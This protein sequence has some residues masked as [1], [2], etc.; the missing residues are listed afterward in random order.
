MPAQRSDSSVM[1]EVH[2]TNSPGEPDASEAEKLQPLESISELKEGDGNVVKLTTKDLENLEKIQAEL[3]N[4]TSYFPH[5]EQS[6]DSNLK[7]DEQTNKQ[8]I[9]SNVKNVK[10]VVK[11]QNTEQCKIMNMVSDNASVNNVISSTGVSSGIT[12][13][14]DCTVTTG[15]SASSEIKQSL[16]FVPKHVS[17]T[18]PIVLQTQNSSVKSTATISSL[19]SVPCVSKPK[20]MI[21]TETVLNSGIQSSQISNPVGSHLTTIKGTEVKVIVSQAI[22]PTQTALVS[23]P[24]I[25]TSNALTAATLKRTPSSTIG[26]QMITKVIIK[27]NPTTHQPAVTPIAGSLTAT[28]TGTLIAS[29]NLGQQSTI[30]LASPTKTYTMSKS[31]GT[32]G[33]PRIIRS[34]PSTPP[35]QNVVMFSRVKGKVTSPISFA[36]SPQRI[37]PAPSTGCLIPGS[38]VTIVTAAAAAVSSSA[39]ATTIA[40]PVTT[41]SS[42]TKVILKPVVPTTMKPGTN[43]STNQT[44]TVLSNVDNPTT[45]KQVVPVTGNTVQQIQVP[46]SKFH[47]VR[48]VTPPSQNISGTGNKQAT[49]IP[50]TTRPIVTAATTT[51]NNSSQQQSS[52]ISSVVNVSSGAPVKLTL[53]IS[54]VIAGQTQVTSKS[55]SVPQ[56]MLIPASSVTSTSRTNTSMPTMAL[57]QLPAG[58][59]IPAAGGSILM[60]PAQYNIAQLQQ[61]NQ[62]QSNTLAGTQML[63]QSVQ[64]HNILPSPT[65]GN[66][67]NSNV[68]Q[69]NYVPVAAATTNQIFDHNSSQSLSS[70]SRNH[71]NGSTE[72]GDS[73]PRKPCNCTKSQCLKLY[74]DCFANGEFCNNC[75][76]NNCSNNLEHEEERQKAIKACLDRNPLAFHPKIGKGKDGDHERRHTKGCN[77]KRSGCLKNYCEC[78]EAKILCTNLCKCVG[79]KNFEDS[80]ERKT[81]M[82][83]ADAAEVRVQQQAAA[84]TKI[85]SQIQDLPTRPPIISTTGERLPF[86]FITQEV[87][88][89]TCQCLLAQAEDGE[90]SGLPVS[91]LE[92]LVL[93]EFGRCLMQIIEYANKTKVSNT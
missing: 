74:C 2:S 22:S 27:S 71:I 65:P 87:V 59:L 26:N 39:L 3:D 12:K 25:N 66:N 29:D 63:I 58:T 6:V 1:T 5:K 10:P 85:S 49:L 79:C 56:R 91:T 70:Y 90:R 9:S 21:K 81:L 64:P 35:K 52:S 88:E 62:S 32:L 24:Q 19:Q 76:C 75:N 4:L 51:V 36:K 50:V 34:V 23:V 44:N 57:R 17:S 80:S 54:P 73:R 20:E 69:T 55:S 68:Q 83:L 45:G 93:E 60:V 8:K 28:N 38:K 78:Y 89:A 84:K 67:N 43:V 53:P 77:C 31:S 7:L 11:S 72:S 86:A 16:L 30:L 15:V 46:G 33:T 18:I 37:A 82:H 13:T 14:N 42:P 40:K 61:T 41:P 48:L 47:Y 92:R